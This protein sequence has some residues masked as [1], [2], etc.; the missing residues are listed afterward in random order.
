LAEDDGPSGGLAESLR[1]AGMM[2]S[3]P[4]LLSCPR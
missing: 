1:I 3:L 2:I 4:L